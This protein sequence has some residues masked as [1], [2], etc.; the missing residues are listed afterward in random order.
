MTLWNVIISESVHG[1][2]LIASHLCVSLG[3][4]SRSLASSLGRLHL[5]T[6]FSFFWSIALAHLSLRFIARDIGQ[7]YVFKRI[8]GHENKILRIT[9]LYHSNCL[10]NA[11][12][13]VGTS[14]GPQARSLPKM[15]LHFHRRSHH[16]LPG[17]SCA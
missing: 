3:L 9:A 14:W 6:E 17:I 4:R 10:L 2:Y 8:W 16:S 1:H 11:G 7:L 13:D 5:E 15:H 12:G